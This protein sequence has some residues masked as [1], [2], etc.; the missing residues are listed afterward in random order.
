MNKPWFAITCRGFNRGFNRRFNRLRGGCPWSGFRH[1]SPGIRY[2]DFRY[3]RRIDRHGTFT[4]R[5]ACQPGFD[6]VEKLPGK[7][8]WRIHAPISVIDHPPHI[9][10]TIHGFCQVIKKGMKWRSGTVTA[11]ADAVVAN[12]NL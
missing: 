11:D 7:G 9:K 6:T 12:L 4:G 10:K 1:G 5:I 2:R 3:Y 8:K